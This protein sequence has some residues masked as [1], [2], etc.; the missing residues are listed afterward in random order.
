[1]LAESSNM[2]KPLRFF[3]FWGEPLA[4]A[5]QFTGL[6]VLFNAYTTLCFINIDD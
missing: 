6:F 2:R 4:A 3:G 5:G 1:M